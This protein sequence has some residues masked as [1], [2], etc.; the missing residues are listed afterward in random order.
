MEQ[1]YLHFD[2]RSLPWSVWTIT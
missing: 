1:E 2:Q